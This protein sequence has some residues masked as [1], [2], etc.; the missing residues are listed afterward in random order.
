MYRDYHI[1]NTIY[2]IPVALMQKIISSKQYGVEAM[3]Q[4]G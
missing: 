3:R 1:Y 4:T 2:N